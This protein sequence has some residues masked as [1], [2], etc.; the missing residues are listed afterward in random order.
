[1]AVIDD[2]KGLS[3]TSAA[4]GGVFCAFAAS[5]VVTGGLNFVPPWTGTPCSFNEGEG[6]GPGPGSGAIRRAFPGW[7]DERTFPPVRA[8]RTYPL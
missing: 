2:I 3:Y 8:E 6:G 7:K 4:Q 5:G 1:M